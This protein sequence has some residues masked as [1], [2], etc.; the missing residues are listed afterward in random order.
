MRA[1]PAQ[2]TDEVAP[3]PGRKAARPSPDRSVAAP[4][5]QRVTPARA[6]R[7]RGR[8]PFAALLSDP[9]SDMARDGP[10]YVRP[11]IVAAGSGSRTDWVTGDGTLDAASPPAA[12][13][14][15]AG[16]GD[17]NLCP[18]HERLR[19]HRPQADRHGRR[20]RRDARAPLP[21]GRGGGAAARHRRAQR[22]PR[23]RKADRARG[24]G[25]ASTRGGAARRAMRGAPRLGSTGRSS[26]LSRRDCV[27]RLR[28]AGGSERRPL[29][30][31]RHAPRLSAP[32]SHGRERLRR[33]AI[34]T[35]ESRRQDGKEWPRG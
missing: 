23:A 2:R 32:P 10:E 27:S 26:R 21:R 29:P 19:R 7:P 35:N 14:A 20:V 12:A 9:C 16:G 22:E 8:L 6:G 11:W 28:P 30:G 1:A 31:L 15:V 4:P 13:L 25:S 24:R 3:A 33:L 34:R 18:E 17:G 5:P